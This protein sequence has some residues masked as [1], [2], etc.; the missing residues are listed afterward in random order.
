MKVEWHWFKKREEKAP[1]SKRSKQANMD[2][3]SSGGNQSRIS[4]GGWLVKGL[5]KINV[6]LAPADPLLRFLG[7]CGDAMQ[8]ISIGIVGATRFQSAFQ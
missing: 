3:T 2:L 5:K 8:G 1:G 7:R 6:G 4:I